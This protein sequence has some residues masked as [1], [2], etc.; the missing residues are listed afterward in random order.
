[1]THDPLVRAPRAPASEPPRLLEREAALERLR[2]ALAEARAGRGGLVLVSGEAGVGKS[3]LVRAFRLEAVPHGARV[4]EGACDPLFAP[5]PLGPFADVAATTGGMLAERVEAGARPHEVLGPLLQE[6]SRTSLL[7]VEDVH[8]AD[9]ATLDL[10]RLLGRRAE[11][12]GALVV[13]TFRDDEPGGSR[14]LRSV[15]GSLSTEASV[16]RLALRPLSVEAV[17]ELASPSGVDAAALHRRTGGNPFFVT[18]VLAVGGSGVP[19]TVR[20]AVLARA[21]RLE[22]TARRLLETVAVLAGGAGLG[23][24]GELAP[25]EL[26][27]LDDCVGG[28]M[29]RLDRTA[30]AFRHELARLA[31]EESLAP[32]RRR[33]LH[34]AALAVLAA[35][36]VPDDARLAHHAEAA[37]DVEAVRV[38]APRAAARAARVG[39]H[40]EAASQWARALRALEDP[41]GEAAVE[42]L[43]RL[44]HECF[45]SGQ[46][47]E[48]LE[49][50]RAAAELLHRAGD[51]A[52]EG[53]QLCWISRLQW[54]AG[55]RA[56]ADAAAAAAVALLE[57]L[58]PG[59]ELALAYAAMAARRQIALDVAGTVEWAGRAIALAERL[60]ET[61]IVARASVVLGSVEA[62]AGGGRETLSN[63][64]RL[65]LTAG[66]EDTAAL[67]YGNLAAAAVRSRDWPTADRVLAEGIRYATDRD[68]ETDRSYMVTWRA[69]AALERS[70]WDEAA[71]GVGSVLADPGTAPVVRA[72]A[73]IV[74]GLARAR[75]GDPGVWEAL[76][77]AL[78]IGRDAAEL[79]KLAPLGLARAEAAVIGGDTAR[80]EAELEPFA[81]TV[82][83][84]RWVAGGLALWGRRLGVRLPPAD[85]LP[86]PFDRELAGAHAEAAEAWRRLDA[87]YDAALALAWSEDTA[88]LRRS[89][90]ALLE[91]GARP[92][93]TLVARR[94]RERGARGV[95]RGPRP[96]T[97]ANAA[98]LTRRELEV[99]SLVA[100][101][102]RN[103][104][105][106]ER[107]FVSPRTVDHHVSAVLRK[108]GAQTRGEAVAAAAQLDLLPGR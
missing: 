24:L 64:L 33:S 80:A 89:H 71:L 40:R 57:R 42:L 74:L 44:A 35:R 38:H 53:E 81:D 96:S 51:D 94:L 41:T 97:R 49:A 79:P 63:G 7:V 88:E 18:E 48:S 90:A 16:R 65:A 21:G 50:R 3:A 73:L 104:E 103:A 76:D 34:A 22:P 31:I 28:G 17:A 55:R 47:E 72:T 86:E 84:D 37:G 61:E 4:L 99:L 100:D 20:D 105:I 78:A 6:L 95:T 102:L 77:E 43:E 85:D 101:G 108:L 106:A 19:A 62:F 87:P 36:P 9:E 15:L 2:T 93:A 12:T 68:L 98:A 67:A 92:A 70:R 91:L 58:P 60:G 69:V 107:L 82:L 45:L 23:L 66:I 13:V 83:A 46:I 10:L 26:D 8:W 52:R 5:R 39:A 54:Y 56:E 30:V 25:R 75:R 29:L 1:V 59:R 11:P 32:G 27:A 14:Q